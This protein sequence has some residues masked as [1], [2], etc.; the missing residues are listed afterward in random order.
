MS[1]VSVV[2]VV[3]EKSFL[4]ENKT[5]SIKIPIPEIVTGSDK[6]NLIVLIENTDYDITAAAKHNLVR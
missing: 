6:L 1:I 2:P 4:V 5:G 3:A